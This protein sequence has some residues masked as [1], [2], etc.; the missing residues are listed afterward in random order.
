MII[1]ANFFNLNLKRLIICMAVPL[2]VF[3]GSSIISGDKSAW[4]ETAVLPA[5]SV[6]AGWYVLLWAV[7]YLLL[8]ISCCLICSSST[9]D[10]SEALFFYGAQL[11]LSFFWPVI[12]FS[13][14]SYLLAFVWLVLLWLFVLVMA[15]K[16]RSVNK[17]AAILQVPYLLWLA[18][19]GYW[20]FG[21]YLIN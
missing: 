14:Q 2:A 17:R 4:Y 15:V 8:G 18:Y 1:K 10:K 6:S 12:F 16:F 5:A 3:A 11:F 7:S 21:V 19:L 20:N 13:E 9:A